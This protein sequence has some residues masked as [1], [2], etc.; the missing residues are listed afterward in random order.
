MTPMIRGLVALS[1]LSLS[2]L[3]F[4]GEPA[5]AAAKERRVEISVTDDGF[6]PSPIK[7]KKDEPL[8]LAVTRK[9]AATCATRLVLDEGKIDAELP[10]N[11][12]VEL[13]FTPTKTGTIKY[14]CQMSKMIAGVLTVE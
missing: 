6:V 7:V 1:V 2:G 3:V 4:A 5:K 12:T 9:T 13:K 14:G 8:V 10:L 11:K